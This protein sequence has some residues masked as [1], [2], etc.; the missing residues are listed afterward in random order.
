MKVEKQD[1]VGEHV[2]CPFWVSDLGVK[3]AGDMHLLLHDLL[4]FSLV[5][6]SYL[7]VEKIRLSKKLVRFQFNMEDHRTVAIKVQKS[8]T[9]L[10]HRISKP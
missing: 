6:V 2:Q 1:I 3:Q 7:E 8:I 9:K 10:V 5:K 4:K